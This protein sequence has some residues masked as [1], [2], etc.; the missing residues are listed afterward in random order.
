MKRIGIVVVAYNAAR[1]LAAVLD[2]IPTDFADQLHEVLVCDDH[3]ADSTHLVGVDYRGRSTLPLT[4][5]RHSQNLGYGGNQK[6]GYRHA[7]DRGW[8]VAVLLH[9]DGQYAP[10]ALPKMVAPILAGSSEVVIGSRMMRPGSALAGGMPRYKYV[11]NR[12]LSTVQNQVTGL[13]LSEWH[14]GYRAYSVAA[15]RQVDF[16]SDSDGFDFDTEITLQLHSA[17]CRFEE[18]AIPTFYGDEVCH[19][20][21]LRYAFDVLADTAR[22]ASDRAGVGSGRLAHQPQR[23]ANAE[24]PDGTHSI[25]A[26]WTAGRPPASILNLDCGSGHLATLLA[27]HGHGVTGV[28]SQPSAMAE[29]RLDRL[30]LADRQAARDELGDERFDVVVIER[31]TSAAAATPPGDDQLVD[32]SL[33][34]DLLRWARSRLAPGGRVIV[35][36]PVRPLLGSHAKI[37]F[38]ENRDQ[39]NRFPSVTELR[40]LF[41]AAGME[42]SRIAYPE[43]ENGGEATGMPAPILRSLGRRPRRIATALTPELRPRWAARSALVE[44]RPIV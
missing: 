1:T 3:S 43:P 13:E 30:V 20:D 7:V 44:L 11:G 36:T 35:S 15:L 10:E 24:D 34:L 40:R 29:E 26:A 23:F 14:S 9:G 32:G 5:I 16:E 22:F 8:D 31:L 28:C 17:G 42:V 33:Q 2:R 21:G 6:S 12:I 38:L 18:I 37:P 41:S 19:V 27:K 25:I 39:S 4:V